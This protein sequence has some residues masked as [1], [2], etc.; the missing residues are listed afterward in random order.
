MVISRLMKDYHLEDG[1]L[2]IKIQEAW[3][4]LMDPAILQRTSS[5]RFEKGELKI[6]TISAVLARELEYQKEEIKNAINA[7]LRIEAIQK[8][9][10]R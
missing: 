2:E 8:V 1:L 7:V 3:N 10:I 5:V 9:D 6:R 4:G